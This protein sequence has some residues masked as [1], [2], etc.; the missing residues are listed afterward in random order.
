MTKNIAKINLKKIFLHFSFW[1]VPNHKNTTSHFNKMNCLKWPHT[2]LRMGKEINKFQNVGNL[3]LL[4]LCSRLSYYGSVT[5]NR[6][7]FS[8]EGI[9]GFLIGRFKLLKSAELAETQIPPNLL[10]YAWETGFRI[11]SLYQGWRE[12]LGNIW[13][14][15]KTL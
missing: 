13:A 5:C 14:K 3:Y 10:F 9:S 1:N 11:L 6:R 15:S 2:L 12:N 4:I 8:I 7:K